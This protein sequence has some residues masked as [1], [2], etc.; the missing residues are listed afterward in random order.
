VE[1]KIP[2]TLFASSGAAQAVRLRG[3]KIRVRE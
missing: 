1:R 3:M 2:Q